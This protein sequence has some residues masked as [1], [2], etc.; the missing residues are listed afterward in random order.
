MAVTNEFERDLT[1]QAHLKHPGMIDMIV[2]QNIADVGDGSPGIQRCFRNY[3]H[4][5][6]MEKDLDLVGYSIKGTSVDLTNAKL[7]EFNNIEATTISPAQWVFVGEADQALK[8]ADSPTFAGLTLSAGGAITSADEDLSFT[9]GRMGIGSPSGDI[10]FL[11]HRDALNTTNYSVKQYPDGST[12]I[13]SATSH[14]INFCINDVS[15]MNMT[16]STFNVGIILDMGA[17]SIELDAGQ[18]VDGVDISAWIDQDLRIAVS[19]TF[20]GLTLAGNLVM[21]T[22]DITFSAGGTVDGVDVSAHTH[23]GAGQGGTV[24]FSSL[25]GDITYGQLDSIVDTSGVGS[26]NKISVAT[27]VHNDSDG[28]TKIA[29]VNTTGRTV[30]DH[31][32][33]YTDANVRTAVLE[34]D[35]F[36][37]GWDGDITHA[38]TQNAI[39]DSLMKGHYGTYTGNGSTSK[40][41]TVGNNMCVMFV[42][43][44]RYTAADHDLASLWFKSLGDSVYAFGLEVNQDYWKEDRINTLGQNYFTVD[45]SGTNA[46]PNKSGEI[47]HYFAWCQMTN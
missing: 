39:W 41:I 26:A 33:K 12:F 11:G 34:N 1:N 16:V 40:T 46:H 36:G 28:S 35:V 10:M 45:D 42:M 6:G 22:D 7:Q 24:A 5:G 13:N 25:S 37:S 47:Y 4:E 29:H 43:V 38:P 15:K 31:H 21:G 8:Q 44:Y 3:L 14:S 2:F 17:N 30:S 20:A 32:T 18:T 9:F 19:P 23:N 27:H